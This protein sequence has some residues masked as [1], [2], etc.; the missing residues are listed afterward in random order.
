MTRYR[1]TILI[2]VLLFIALVFSS[3]VPR[4]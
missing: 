1:N 4:A 3:C 2:S